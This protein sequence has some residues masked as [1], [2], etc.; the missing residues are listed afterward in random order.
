[1]YE[2]QIPNICC[3]IKRGVR[4]WSRP[5]NWASAWDRP[6]SDGSWLHAGK[7]SRASQ[8]KKKADLF[9]ETHFA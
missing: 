3:G 4:G 9:R 1:M 8:S 7:K 2:K 6:P 5:R